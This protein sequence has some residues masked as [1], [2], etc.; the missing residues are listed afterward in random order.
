M[1]AEMQRRPKRYAGFVQP[2]TNLKVRTSLQTSQPGQS[3]SPRQLTDDMLEDVGKM[4]VVGKNYQ[5][6][7]EM[8]RSKWQYPVL[9]SEDRSPTKP[10]VATKPPK[11]LSRL[12][13]PCRLSRKS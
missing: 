1:L 10:T 8:E 13:R 5:R 11:P 12:S 7:L 4:P 3:V 6:K 2:L 9:P